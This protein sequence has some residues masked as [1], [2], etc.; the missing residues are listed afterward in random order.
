MN[1]PLNIFFVGEVSSGKSSLLNALA[2]GI[3]SNASLQ[4]ETICPEIYNFDNIQTK[5]YSSFKKIASMLEEK[6]LKNKFFKQSNKKLIKEPKNIVD[7]DNNRIDFKPQFGMPDFMVTDF[8]GLNDS[9]AFYNDAEKSGSENSEDMFFKLVKDNIAKCDLLVYITK[10]ETAFINQS[11]INLFQKLKL[12]RDDMMTN[13][14]KY[15][16]L[17][18]VVNKFDDPYDPDLVEIANDISSKLQFEIPIFRVSSHKLLV[19]NIIQHKLSVPIPKFCMPEIHKI[20]QNANVIMTKNQ[21]NSVT[22]HGKISYQYIESN[23]D[24]DHDSGSETSDNESP[25]N[26][27]HSVESDSGSDFEDCCNGNADL[28]PIYD[29][30]YKGDWNC[31]IDFIKE[32]YEKYPYNASNARRSLLRKCFFKI[33]SIGEKLGKNEL[34]LLRNAYYRFIFDNDI[35]YFVTKI[36]FFI[37]ENIYSKFTILTLITDLSTDAYQINESLKYS[38]ACVIMARVGE[39]FEDKWEFYTVLII[40]KLLENFGYWDKDLYFKMFQNDIIWSSEYRERYYNYEYNGLYY[41]ENPPSKIYR[42]YIVENIYKILS[43]MQN[44]SDAK[45]MCCL[46][47]LTTIDQKF[48]KILDSENK[49]P[50]DIIRDYL[51]KSAVIRMKNYIYNNKGDNETIP[52]L[53]NSKETR[54]QQKYFEIENVLDNFR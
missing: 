22:N 43:K 15:I 18:I 13:F 49:I 10:A 40:Y 7:A 5:A 36:V 41:Y 2:G 12:L 17:C 19:E 8:P 25:G 9:T 29:Y 50:Y 1:R 34:D 30:Q 45:N 6:H 47:Y 46:I 38:M 53:F 11:E 33:K 16:K 52:I 31:F 54:G 42:T 24:I 20:F 37:N 14:G 21:K 35:K 27:F 32:S 39:K 4:R 23:Q 26:N 51:G 48:L 44:D 3:I 28:R